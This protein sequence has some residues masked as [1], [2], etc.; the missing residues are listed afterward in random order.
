MQAEPPSP[1]RAYSQYETPSQSPP[2]EAIADRYVRPG[3]KCAIR[4]I[5]SIFTSIACNNPSNAS[6]SEANTVSSP[7][8]PYLES[9]ESCCN[10]GESPLFICRAAGIK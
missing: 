8:Q 4:L 7:S 2:P 6:A 5:I 9:R 10:E 3:V 1:P